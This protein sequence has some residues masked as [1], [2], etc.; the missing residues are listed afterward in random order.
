MLTASLAFHHV[1]YE[2]SS[3]IF[4]TCSPCS[5]RLEHKSAEEAHVREIDHHSLQPAD[6]VNIALH[7]FFK[8]LSIR[9]KATRGCHAR[10]D[11]EYF[12]VAFVLEISLQ[13]QL[14][15]W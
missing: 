9:D 4:D 11:T 7:Q 6:E 15:Q 13:P 10:G 2:T 5:R 1:R 12:K 14:C 8:A 3:F